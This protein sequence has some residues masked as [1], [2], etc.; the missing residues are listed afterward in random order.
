VVFVKGRF[1][2]PVGIRILPSAAVRAGM[3]KYRTALD[4]QLLFGVGI[5][6]QRHP[7]RTKDRVLLRPG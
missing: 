2:S 7:G 6:P 1:L 4:R 5:T 3:L